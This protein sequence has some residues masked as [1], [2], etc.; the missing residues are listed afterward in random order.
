[1]SLIKSKVTF[2]NQH[3]ITLAGLLETPVTPRGYALFAHCFTCGKDLN[4]A[5]RI[6]RALA[7]QGIAVLRFDF[8]GLGNSSGDFANSNFSSNVD[9]LIA[10]ASFLDRHYQAPDI[11]V[12]HSLGGTAILAAAQHL[13]SVKGVVTIG[14]PAEPSHVIKQFGADVER[15]RVEGESR[16]NLAGR[17]FSIKRQFLEDI[18]N[19]RLENR[20]DELSKALLI[21][22][23]PVDTVVSIEQAQKLYQAAR[24]PKSFISLDKADHLLSHRPDAQYVANCIASWV[25]RYLPQ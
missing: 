14:A 22:H 8:T 23:S 24:H 3:D 25:E 21:F 13:P 12:G 18:D 2:T 11:L 19:H 16:V 17:E 20:L 1:M 5:S 6:S 7:E 9:D 15:I 4:S 10:A